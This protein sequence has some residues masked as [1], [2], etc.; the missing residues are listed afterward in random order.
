MIEIVVV[1]VSVSLLKICFTDFRAT[2][3]DFTD[4]SRNEMGY[5]ITQIEEVDWMV[6]APN[7]NGRRLS[8][9]S[10]MKRP[11]VDPNIQSCSLDQRR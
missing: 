9:A 7:S 6:S 1:F 11:G 10:N 4:L 5:V 2:A 8:S 3:F